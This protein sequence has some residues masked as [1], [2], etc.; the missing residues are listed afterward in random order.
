MTRTLI[1]RVAAAGLAVAVL[2]AWRAHARDMR[3]LE[4]TEHMNR[5]FTDGYE[6]GK[7]AALLRRSLNELAAEV[8]AGLS[9]A[10]RERVARWRAGLDDPL[11]LQPPGPESEN[12]F[13]D[14]DLERWIE[15]R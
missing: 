15:G 9:P 3:R 7:A 14:E 11:G 6:A 4:L 10:Q 5:A 2:A 13:S 8:E 12:A 1:V